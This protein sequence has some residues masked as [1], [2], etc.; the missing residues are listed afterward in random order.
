MLGELVPTPRPIERRALGS[1][2]P[3]SYRPRIKGYAPITLGAL[4][5]PDLVLHPVVVEEPEHRIDPLRTPP[6]P[7]EA[8]TTARPH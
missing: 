4:S 1:R 5:R 3:P 6:L 7:V 8:P 2:T